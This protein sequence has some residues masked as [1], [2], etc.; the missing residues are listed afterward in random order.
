MSSILNL[1]YNNSANIKSNQT[2]NVTSFSKTKENS[3]DKLLQNHFLI[4]SSSRLINIL[5]NTEPRDLRLNS[6]V[7]ELL[8]KFSNE[9]K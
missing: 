3:K 6:S 1:L 9:G 7:D 4:D 8:K 2:L 5:P